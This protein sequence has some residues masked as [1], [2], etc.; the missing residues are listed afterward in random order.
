MKKK[1]RLKLWSIWFYIVY[2]TL[3]Y[4]LSLLMNSF[5][6]LRSLAIRKSQMS[7]IRVLTSSTRGMSSAALWE[8]EFKKK[9][10][11]LNS[12]LKNLNIEKLIQLSNDN[13]GELHVMR[14]WHFC[15]HFA[16]LFDSHQLF[17]FFHIN[18]IGTFY[19]ASLSSSK[20]NSQPER[21]WCGH[22]WLKWT[23]ITLNIRELNR[24]WINFSIWN[25][26]ASKRLRWWD[27]ESCG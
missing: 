20:M 18:P 12:R 21:R 26:I 14:T 10:I 11:D 27:K 4:K 8:I 15:E 3:A 17:K 22:A 5:I 2:F 1:L 25:S 9:E 24:I 7:L 6:L 16:C 23:N 19:P 13:I